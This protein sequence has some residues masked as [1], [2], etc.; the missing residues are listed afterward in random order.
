M[1]YSQLHV[2]RHTVEIIILV[3]P[4]TGMQWVDVVSNSCSLPQA[5]NGYCNIHTPCHRH[6]LGRCDVAFILTATDT[7]WVDVMS[8]PH[9]CHRHILGR[10]DVP[11]ILPPAHSGYC[12]TLC[13]R[14]TLGRCDVPLILQFHKH[15]VGIVILS[16]TGIHWVDVM[17]HSYF[18]STS[19][20]WVL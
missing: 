1:S 20:Q 6:T 19:T 9:S 10:W 8:H 4:A 15:T 18:N 14:H 11:F 13:H 16:A 3:F 12:N 17:S 2:H 5:Q 7:Q